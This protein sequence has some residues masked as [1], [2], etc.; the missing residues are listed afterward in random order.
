MKRERDP[1]DE[2]ENVE[3]VKSTTTDKS[4]GP[5]YVDDILRY[6]R[7]KEEENRPTMA[8]F[9]QRQ[10][11]VT[12][13]M[14]TILMDWMSSVACEYHL[15]NETLFL[16]FA[17]LN[18]MFDMFEIDSKNR[19]QLLGT[20]CLWIA[21]K[22]EEIF[23]P[24]MSDYV[25]ITDNA[26]CNDEMISMESTILQM[27]NYNLY[28]PSPYTFLCHFV[29]ALGLKRENRSF[30]ERFCLASFILEI[31]MLRLESLD[32]L[33]SHMAAAALLLALTTPDNPSNTDTSTEN[34][35]DK[36]F[37]INANDNSRT[38]TDHLINYL[39]DQVNCSS[40]ELMSLRDTLKMWR[41]SFLDV[42]RVT[43]LGNDVYEKYSSRRYCNVATWP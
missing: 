34:V 39:V 24:V 14:R 26:Y 36:L 21:S 29:H 33:P 23:P 16:S 6:L 27:M 9:L 1:D 15:A 43:K 42:C 8:K 19:I 35:I 13:N 11:I 10:K 2:E 38:Q 31:A 17:V 7:Q 30:Q 32:Y 25:Y 20:T 5:E 37:V 28:I 40:S 41:H 3:L 12:A 18:R 4:S 22:L